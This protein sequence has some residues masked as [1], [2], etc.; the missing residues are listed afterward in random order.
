MMVDFGVFQTSNRFFAQFSNESAAGVFFFFFQELILNKHVQIK[1]RHSC[2]LVDEKF[3]LQ[4]PAS[5]SFQFIFCS[6]LMH[7]CCIFVDF[8]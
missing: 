7:M 3:N 5:A 2:F 8:S 1:N 6:F 4:S